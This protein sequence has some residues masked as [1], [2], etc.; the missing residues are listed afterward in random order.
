M[1]NE[2]VA[3]GYHARKLPPGKDESDV[4]KVKNEGD[5]MVKVRMEEEELRHKAGAAS[6]TCAVVTSGHKFTLKKISTAS[7]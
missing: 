4:S 1:A 7:T 3:A 5:L 2:R 6:S